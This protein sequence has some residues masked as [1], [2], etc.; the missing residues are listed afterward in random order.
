MESAQAKVYT[1]EDYYN[2]PED[3]RAELIDGQIYY[4]AAPSRIH[5]R[6]LSDLHATIY[7]YI[8]SKGGSCEVYPAPFA[9]ELF[10]DR[11][12]IVDPD[13]KS[14]FV[15]YLEQVN[16]KAEVYSFQDKIK[17]NIYEDLYIGFASLEL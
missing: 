2:L 12:N 3:T 9:V 4:Q 1:E 17:G 5:Q 6:V 7:N 10:D 16:F 13:R 15:Y 8:K 14:V 11:K